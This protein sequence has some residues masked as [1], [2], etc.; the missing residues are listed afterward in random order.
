MVAEAEVATDWETEVVEDLVVEAEAAKGW[1]EEEGREKVAGA[2][3]AV[4]AEVAD[5]VAA[6]WAGEEDREMV[7]KDRVEPGAVADSA[8]GKA[9]TCRCAVRCHPISG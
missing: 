4:E 1:A 8:V 9:Y 2:G 5:S 7:M 3:L 6:G